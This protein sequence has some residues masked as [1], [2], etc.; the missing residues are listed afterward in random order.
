MKRYI[1]PSADKIELELA[2]IITL[3]APDEW[4]E[5]DDTAEAPKT[6]FD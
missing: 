5:E 2:D 4:A 3:S 6:W 1:T